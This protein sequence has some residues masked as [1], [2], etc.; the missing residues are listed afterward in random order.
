MFVQDDTHAVACVIETAVSTRFSRNTIY[1][2]AVDHP[3]GRTV[4][5]HY[6]PCEDFPSGADELRAALR[7]R[8]GNDL[9]PD[10]FVA[11]D[12]LPAT[13]AGAIDHDHLKLC[14]ERVCECLV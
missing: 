5:C 8:L 9:V 14:A 13:A 1:L 12:V 11:H 4:V 7:Q 2:N 3:H 6:V 10:V